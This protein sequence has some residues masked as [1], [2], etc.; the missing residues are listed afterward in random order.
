VTGG[1]RKLH[2][3]ELLDLY[4]SPSIVRIIKSRMKWI[5][6][7]ALTEEKR[8]LHSLPRTSLQTFPPDILF[9]SIH[10]PPGSLTLYNLY[11]EKDRYKSHE[12][13]R[14]IGRNPTL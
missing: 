7:V 8:S 5:G 13:E 10:L 1:W 11:N 12:K 3:E 9:F 4:S 6:H 14:I 2:K